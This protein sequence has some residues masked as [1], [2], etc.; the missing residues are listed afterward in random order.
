VSLPVRTTAEADAQILAIDD[1]WRKN[2]T[3]A[4]DLFADELAAAF[5]MI[6]LTP[7]I[8]R[9]YPHPSVPGTRRM[10]LKGSRY[11]VYYVPVEN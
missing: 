5:D 6:A 4:A 11:Q 2:R 9:P 10:L 7:N 1:W 3:A 8:G